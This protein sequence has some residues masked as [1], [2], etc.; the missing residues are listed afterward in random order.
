MGKISF[1]D[2][3]MRGWRR[4]VEMIEKQVNCNHTVMWDATGKCGI[5]VFCGATVKR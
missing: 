4:Y 3:I 2:E 5:C 1:E